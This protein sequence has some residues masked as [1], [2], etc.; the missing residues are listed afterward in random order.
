MKYRCPKCHNECNKGDIYC[1]KCG[2]KIIRDYIINEKDNIN[3]NGLENTFNNNKGNVFS[4]FIS[5]FYKNSDNIFSYMLSNKNIT[6]DS[7]LMN[8]VI[9]TV[10]ISV[11]L[12]IVVFSFS[13]D[14]NTNKL[15]LQFNNYIQNPE[16]IPEL[17]EP[18]TF[19]ELASNLSEVEKFLELFLKY[20][21]NKT[22]PLYIF[23]IASF[24]ETI[25]FKS[26]VRSLSPNFTDFPSSVFSILFDWF[27]FIL[28]SSLLT[29]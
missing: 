4:S 8:I 18:K 13:D 29:S 15:N 10:I 23:C 12:A 6:Y 22:V 20:S 3:H 26:F 14:H 21:W 17:Q 11:V 2:S 16:R 24:L 7:I 1:S 27:L 19:E 25:A 9:C 28:S 5:K